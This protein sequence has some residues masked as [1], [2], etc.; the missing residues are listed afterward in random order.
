[1]RIEVRD[2]NIKCKKIR[3]DNKAVG[4]LKTLKGEIVP[5]TIKGSD[6]DNYRRDFGIKNTITLDFGDEKINVKITDIKRD[7]LIPRVTDVDF[8]QVI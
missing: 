4:V 7:R 6:M 8:E 5:I 1:M 3:R 2:V